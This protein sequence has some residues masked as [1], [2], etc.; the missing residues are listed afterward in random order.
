M[1]FEGRVWQEGS[2]WLVEVPA[3][4]AMTQGREKSE[5]FEMIEDLVVTMAHSPGFEVKVYPYPG[6]RFEIGGNDVGT[7]VSLL[8]RRQREKSGISLDEATELL[9]ETPQNVWARYEQGRAVP[10]IEALEELLRAIAPDQELV[11]RLAC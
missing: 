5:A 6:D 2:H 3:L 10:T 8:L 11:W 4:N 7:L 1:R 9:A